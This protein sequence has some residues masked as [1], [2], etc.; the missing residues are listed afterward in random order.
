MLAMA[1]LTTTA[2]VGGKIALDAT[3]RVSLT[4]NTRTQKSADSSASSEARQR[5]DHRAKQLI[6]GAHRIV[7]WDPVACCADLGYPVITQ[8]GPLRTM[9][10][11]A[12][13]RGAVRWS[14]SRAPATLSRIL[15]S[16]HGC[17]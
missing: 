14:I 3:R 1:L 11:A 12:G 13:K 5:E 8:P 16:S 6:R 17:V 2:V 15:N 7:V 10:A 9:L 4:A